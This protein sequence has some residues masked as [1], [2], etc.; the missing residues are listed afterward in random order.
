MAGSPSCSLSELQDKASLDN[1]RFLYLDLD[2]QRSLTRGRMRRSTYRK[3]VCW[4][5]WGGQRG[6]PQNALGL[7]CIERSPLPEH[8]GVSIT[9]TFAY[10]WAMLSSYPLIS[11][12]MCNDLDGFQVLD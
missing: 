5:G 6:S 8:L 10:I 11:C 7:A 12:S 3:Q 9:H 1:S 4:V 2:G